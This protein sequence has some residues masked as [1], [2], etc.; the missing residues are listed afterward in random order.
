MSKKFPD[1]S[2]AETPWTIKLRP[3]RRVVEIEEDEDVAPRVVQ[4]EVRDT[5][6]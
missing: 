6:H 2:S 1:A 5:A 3:A 4:E